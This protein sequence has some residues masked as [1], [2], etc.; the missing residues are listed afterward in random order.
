MQSSIHVLRR[1]RE[2]RG[3]CGVN[4]LAI[5]A[6]EINAS[7][8]KTPIV[9]LYENSLVSRTARMGVTAM[10]NAAL[11]RVFSAAEAER[12][13]SALLA[14]PK[15]YPGGSKNNASAKVASVVCTRSATI[16]FCI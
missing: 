6:S 12:I 1:T 2:R 10:E 15:R 14:S 11:N 13:P 3:R 9:T 8:R 5:V 4:C 7:R 16:K